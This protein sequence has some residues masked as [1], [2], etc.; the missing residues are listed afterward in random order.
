MTLSV[1]E[2][3]ALVQQAISKM[4]PA[5]EEWVV[6]DQYTI[7]KPWGWVFFYNSREYAT[8]GDPMSQLVGNAPY[9]VNKETH[10]LFPT[11]TADEIEV[12]IADYEATIGRK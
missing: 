11:G 4:A 10:E 9:I 5:D 7:E 2:A 12:Y 3:R 6:L 8:T 1:K